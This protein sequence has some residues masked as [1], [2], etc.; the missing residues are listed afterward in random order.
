MINIEFS[1]VL[2]RFICPIS[3][4]E[5]VFHIANTFKPN[6]PELF[7]TNCPLPLTGSTAS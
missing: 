3:V 7:D 2:L 4:L 6:L 1:N 5:G